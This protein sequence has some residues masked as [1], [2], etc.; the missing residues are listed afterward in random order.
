MAVPEEVLE[1]RKGTEDRCQVD[2]DKNEPKVS[3]EALVLVGVVPRLRASQGVRRRCQRHGGLAGTRGR[4]RSR[5][6]R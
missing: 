4:R 6:S 3:T 5:A 2:Y 1:V